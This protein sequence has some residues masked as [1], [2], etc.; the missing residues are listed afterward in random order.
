MIGPFVL[1]CSAA[2]ALYLGRGLEIWSFGA[3]GSGLLPTVTALILLGASLASFSRERQGEAAPGGNLPRAAGYA[4]GLVAIPPAVMLLGMLP[5][6]ALFT[7][8]I[9]RLMEGLRMSTVILITSASVLGNWLVFDKLLHV[10]LPKPLF[11]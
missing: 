3:P 4:A 2:L 10:A 7:A 5:T 6:L 1:A 9:L 11:W 8:L